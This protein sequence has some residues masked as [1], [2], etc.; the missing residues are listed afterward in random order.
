MRGL[1]HIYCGDGKGK[2]TAAAGLAV[3][4]AGCGMKVLFAQFMKSGPAGEINAFKKIDGIT[5]LRGEG[6]TKFAWEM[7]EREKAAA[8][9]MQ[10]V[11]LQKAAAW[12]EDYDMVVLD[13]A[14][15]TCGAGFLE[16]KKLYDFLDHKPEK[17]EVVLTGRNPADGLIER[18]D[19]V[20]EIKKIK[21]PY[22]RGI[23]ARKGIEQ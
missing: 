19:Y 3:R 18:A 4:S 1:I 11:I 12:A 5:V 13:E 16:L 14:V 10:D 7:D 21:H 15:G 20:S 8:C 17:L 22:D 9:R 23:C 6:D 2:T